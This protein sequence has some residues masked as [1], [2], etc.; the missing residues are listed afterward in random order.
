MKNAEW[1]LYRQR[2]MQ[3][4]GDRCVRCGTEWCLIVHH[5]KSKNNGGSDRADNLITVCRKCHFKLEDMTNW[6]LPET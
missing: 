2:I 5:I 6:G 1:Q 4:D 3:I